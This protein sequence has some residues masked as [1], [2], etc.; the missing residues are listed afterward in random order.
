MVTIDNFKN[1][2]LCITPM[3]ILE[4]EHII[5]L[6]NEKR[7]TVKLAQSYACGL[8]RKACSFLPFKKV[9]VKNKTK[10]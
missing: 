9:G 2:E 8:A 6:S 10:I 7:F 3:H 4:Q 5:K 1:I